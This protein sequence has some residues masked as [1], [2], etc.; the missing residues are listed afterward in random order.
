MDNR[1]IDK[2]E[3]GCSPLEAIIGVNSDEAV[4][5]ATKQLVEEIQKLKALNEALQ[6]DID[7]LRASN[8]EL[9]NKPLTS[10]ENRQYE[11]GLKAGRRQAAQT[12]IDTITNQYICHTYSIDEER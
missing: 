7:K 3:Q 1:I 5:D 12:I 6:K 10:K 11:A 8:N 9:R 4:F 2:L